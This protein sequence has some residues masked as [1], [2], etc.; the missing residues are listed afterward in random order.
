MG[1]VGACAETMGILKSGAGTRLFKLY[2]MVLKLYTPPPVP[3]SPLLIQK[4]SSCLWLK[5][6]LST[7]S[8]WR[9]DPVGRPGIN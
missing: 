2:G 5:L 6:K 3:W 8:K 1:S 4:A 9:D 7:Q